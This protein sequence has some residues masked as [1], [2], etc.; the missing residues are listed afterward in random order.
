M[1]SQHALIAD[2]GGTNARFALVDPA[3]PHPEPMHARAL[4][5]VDFASLQHAANHY[6]QTVGARPRRAA[7]A[8][9]CPVDGDE[10]RLTNRAWSCSREELRTSLGLDEL[11][12]LND[13]GA[14]AW[15]VT[16]LRPD[17]RVALYG[18]VAEPLAGP[19]SV[20][21]PGTG[22]GVGFLL[23]AQPGSWRVVETEGGH[24]SFAPLD[25]EER[26]IAQWL[27]ARHGRVSNERL[28]CAVTG[29][30]RWMRCFVARP[31]QGSAIPPTSS[32]QRSA[33]RTRPRGKR[34]RGSARYSAASPA[35]AR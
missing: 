32:P 3:A 1:P 21:G 7:I 35:I 31:T 29:C 27:T 22:L 19:I 18:P 5:T 30:R 8:V 11:Q 34:W 16:A 9:A 6:L 17:D 25:D 15:A 2:I 20:L 4:S 23:G 10:I 24:V 14:V 33:A 28:L 12:L 13:F 26:A